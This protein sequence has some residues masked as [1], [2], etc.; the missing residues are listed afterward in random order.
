MIV[1]RIIDFIV[2]IVFKKL[3]KYKHR[4]YSVNDKQW[5]AQFYSISLKKCR[6]AKQSEYYAI[7]HKPFAFSHQPLAISLQPSAISHQPFAFSLQPLAF[8]ASINCNSLFISLSGKKLNRYPVIFL[9]FTFAGS[10]IVLVLACK[11]N[12]PK[13]S[14]LIV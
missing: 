6:V 12:I 4:N 9:T 5:I 7:C 1:I 8:S 14:S 2:I 10:F 11:R 13:P 3:C